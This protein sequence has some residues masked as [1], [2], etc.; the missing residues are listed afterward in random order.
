MRLVKYNYSNDV[1]CK[2]KLIQR[3]NL[4]C[5]I[6][7][8]H[9]NNVVTWLRAET[10]FWL[11]TQDVRHFSLTALLQSNHVK[12]IP[13][14]YINEFIIWI[15]NPL[16]VSKM[17][18]WIDYLNIELTS[19]SKRTADVFNILKKSIYYWFLSR[20]ASSM[21]KQSSHNCIFEK[22]LAGSIFK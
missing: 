20:V 4:W 12:R 10:F 22:R 5:K 1:T 16:V 2:G 18:K 17:Q 21:F 19:R 7:L 3:Y 6:I 13:Q 15:L 14:E 8:Q 9:C 11:G